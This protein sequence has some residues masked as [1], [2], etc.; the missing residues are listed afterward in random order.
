MSSQS[1]DDIQRAAQEQFVRQ[2]TRYGAGHILSIPVAVAVDGL[3]NVYVAGGSSQ[4]AFKITPGGTITQLI[5]LFG[6]GGGN[7]LALPS[8]LTVTPGG[9]VYICSG[10]SGST[11]FTGRSG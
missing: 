4:N 10:S 6:D 5:D 8:D 9:T 11:I 7:L 1:L 2:S 3:Q